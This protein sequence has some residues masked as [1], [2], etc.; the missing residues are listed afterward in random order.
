[1]L[2]ARDLQLD[3]VLSDLLAGKCTVPA[4]SLAVL[5]CAAAQSGLADKAQ[6][7]ANAAGV[8]L[9]QA[10]FFTGLIHWVQEGLQPA[11]APRW[12]SGP[13]EDERG[14]TV[15]ETD[16]EFGN[17]S[18]GI[19]DIDASA[20]VHADASGQ[21]GCDDEVGAANSTRKRTAA[22]D[23]LE[24]TGSPAHALAGRPSAEMGVK[25]PRLTIPSGLHKLAVRAK[26][27]IL[28]QQGALSLHASV[29]VRDV[30]PKYYRGYESAF[31]E[32]AT[33]SDDDAQQ[34]SGSFL[35]LVY[36]SDED[37]SGTAQL[38]RNPSGTCE[39][40]HPEPVLR[41]VQ[42]AIQLPSIQDDGY[43]KP[44]PAAQLSEASH[45]HLVEPV[46]ATL[47]LTQV[48]SPEFVDSA[49]MKLSRL[50]RDQLA[51]QRQQRQ[52]SANFKLGK[53]LD[54]TDAFFQMELC[55]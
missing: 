30:F 24:V 22:K 31:D 29:S 50:G 37:D 46:A 14:A 39:D 17:S 53:A 18:D 8:A 15:A 35:E 12:D 5:I 4:Q 21:L 27:T 52:A 49:S 51:M 1:M 54:V 32:G 6:Q 20:E 9:K 55:S 28:E 38:E 16:E 48:L 7:L 42:S 47:V 3:R 11:H 19:E 26:Q 43:S 13:N 25:R 10:A 33:D 41:N 2:L 45:A 40:L 44:V 34:P 36:S 23:V